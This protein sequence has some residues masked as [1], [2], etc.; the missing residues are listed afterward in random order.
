M[1]TNSNLL[2]NNL[3]S[4]RGSRVGEGGSPSRTFA[5]YVT[6]PPEITQTSD[7]MGIVSFL[8]TDRRLF[9]RIH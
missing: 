3:G 1:N 9:V 8:Q 6:T 4:T 5:D 7:C 2:L